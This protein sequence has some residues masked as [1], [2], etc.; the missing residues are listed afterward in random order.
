[1]N[2]YFLLSWSIL[3]LMIFSI[4][5]ESCNTVRFLPEDQLL[6]KKEPHFDGNKSISSNDLALMIRT[7]PNKRMLNGPKTFLHL[8]N[9]GKILETDST[10]DWLRRPILKLNGAKEIFSMVVGFLTENIGEKPVAIDIP[11]LQRDSANLSKLYF[12]KGFLYPQISYTIVPVENLFEGQKGNVVFT[13]KEGTAYQIDSISCD[14]KDTTLLGIYQKHI[15][16]ITFKEGQNYNHADF[17]IERGRIAQVMRNNGYFTFSPEMIQYFIDSTSLADKQVKVKENITPLIIKTTITDTVKQYK[18]RNIK[19]VIKDVRDSENTIFIPLR[20]DSLSSEQTLQLGIP[21]ERL[22]EPFALN[23]NVSEILLPTLDF[24]FICRRV[25]LKEGDLYSLEKVIKTQKSLQEL[26]MFQFVTINYSPIDSLGLL[27]IKI[28]SKLSARYEVK[29]GAE[30]YGNVSNDNTN[31]GITTNLP[32]IGGNAYFRNR[33]VFGHSELLEFSAAALV[34]AYST[35]DSFTQRFQNFQYIFSDSMPNPYNVSEKVASAWR[36]YYEF[37]TKLNLDFPRFITPFRKINR[38]DLSMLAPKTSIAGAVRL[39]SRAEYQRITIGLSPLNYRWNNTPFKSTQSSQLNI[40]SL[41][42]VSVSRLDS[43]FYNYLKN[44]PPS[45][46]QYRRDFESRFIS[47]DLT[48]TYT[49]SNYMTNRAFPTYYFKAMAE[50]GGLVPFFIDFL[51]VSLRKKGCQTCDQSYKDHYLFDNSN[52]KI[53]Y[54]QYLKASVEGKYYLPL[55]KTGAFVGRALLGG[56]KSIGYSRTIQVVPYQ[57]R[58]FSGGANS[59]RGWFSNTLGPGDTTITKFLPI[60]GEWILEANAELRFNSILSYIQPAIFTDIGNVWFGPSKNLY[61]KG[62]TVLNKNNLVL[63]WD[64]GVGMRLDFSFLIIRFDLAQQLYR[65]SARAFLWQPNKFFE[66]DLTA[67]E[68]KNFN[69]W[70]KYSQ[71]QF[72]IGYPF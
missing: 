51:D 54:G 50:E 8:Y 10:I 26:S 44:L 46:Q 34:S 52:K 35:N 67:P 59:M 7:H 22:T 47:R 27:D 30:I 3:G 63:G 18:I 17:A 71:L 40:L 37:R 64:G 53:D 25:A 24:D 4:L 55:W 58:F 66:V 39:E 11:Q 6:L 29:Y 23:L 21:S 16:D 69:S 32:F 2:K 49:N 14:I 65:P 72:G 9:L 15:K 56:S 19:L 48:Y 33:N 41:D 61:G 68:N 1:M 45:R 60:G 70:T 20:P 36:P 57:S 62:G 38:Q 12:S 31:Y 43:T 5:L 42:L 13:I 28:T